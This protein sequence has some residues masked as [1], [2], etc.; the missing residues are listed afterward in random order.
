MPQNTKSLRKTDTF[1]DTKTVLVQTLKESDKNDKDRPRLCRAIWRRKHARR[2]HVDRQKK[3]ECCE[4][5]RAPLAKT[6]S[7]HINWS[8]VFGKEEVPKALSDFYS[9][10]FEFPNT[11]QG[12][13]L[14]Q[15]EE[16]KKLWWVDLWRTRI[17]DTPVFRC[18]TDLLKSC[19][20]KLRKHKSSP[21]GVTAEIFHMLNDSQ[22]TQ[23]AQAITDMF[24]SLHFE[25][26]WTTVAASLIPQETFPQQAVRIQAYSFA[27]DNEEITR[28]RL[29]GKNGRLTFQFIPNRLSSQDRRFTRSFCLGES[30][31]V[32]E[33]VKK[34]SVVWHSWTSKRP[35]TTYDV[36]SQPPLYSK[37]RVSEQLISVLN[38]WWT[39]SSV[40]V[41]LAGIKSDRRI[42]FQRGLPQGAP[43]SPAIYVA[44]SDY[45]VE[46]LDDGWRYRKYW[47]EVGQHSP[48]KRRLRGR[49]LFVGIKQKGPGAYG[50][51]MHR[52]FLG[53]R[54][55]NR[56]GQ[57]ILDE[58]FSLTKHTFEN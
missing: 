49:H 19:I 34:P 37:K 3:L 26:Q 29:T 27:V 40:E 53:F 21:D 22:L 11:A 48:H 43:E 2:R 16:K 39:Q 54:S 33:G 9:A 47:M 55:G 20:K 25:T 6:K 8:R 24:A 44:V 12:Q 1:K 51:R 42:A 56:F 30:E 38:K 35:S 32:G 57:N 31:R 41:G 50:Q 17:A 28:L 13:T 23:L 15:D 45:V 18:D 5:G 14:K 46:K 52:Q 10:V 4:E 36:P 58:L 7:K